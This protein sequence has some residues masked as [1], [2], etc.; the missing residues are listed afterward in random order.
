V[1]IR[2]L[3]NLTTL[4]NARS[5]H[6]HLALH[7]A[8]D[9]PATML[10]RVDVYKTTGA[11]LLEGG[12]AGTIDVRTRNPSTTPGCTSTATCAASTATSRRTPTPTSGS[13]SRTRGTSALA[14]SAR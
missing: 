1:L 11:D 14:S 7:R 8:P 6:D 4:L 3:P 2:G 13:R 9:I 5:I 12:I 10:K